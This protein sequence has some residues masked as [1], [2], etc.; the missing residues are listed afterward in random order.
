M[1]IEQWTLS[2]I[3]RVENKQPLEDSRVEA[4]ADWIRPEKAA[5]R[6]GGHA[7]AARGEPILWIIGLDEK[8]GVIGAKRQDLAN[9]WAQVKVR[10][11]DIEPYLVK[12]L[13]VP[14]ND[15]QVVTL[16]FETD[17]FPYV[18][19]NSKGGQIQ[20][21]VPWCEGPAI[22][23]AGWRDLM[24]LLSPLQEMPEFEILKGFLRATITGTDMTAENAL[25]WYLEV[26]FCIT[27]KANEPV[28]FPFHRCRADFEISSILSR[29]TFDRVFLEP[30]GRVEHSLRPSLTVRE[31]ATEVL[32]EQA[33]MVKLTCQGKSSMP[34]DRDEVKRKAP[35]AEVTIH[36]LTAHGESPN[37]ISESFPHMTQ[38]EG[39]WGLWKN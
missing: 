39:Q 22:R 23:S 14:V 32:V 18:I 36:L 33:G 26:P 20:K 7:N 35:V 9:W 13:V 27:T 34:V 8:R 16:L 28:I 29:I 30:L 17:R 37:V 31:T 21:E 10:F 4:K 38:E 5:R 24:R 19:K 15:K 25:G 1:E 3:E 2:I 12:D 11:D 6:L